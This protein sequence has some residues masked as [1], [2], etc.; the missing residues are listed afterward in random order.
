MCVPS[1]GEG[2]V[3]GSGK[4]PGTGSRACTRASFVLLLKCM[5]QNFLPRRVAGGG[6]T[7]GQG[8]ARIAVHRPS[9]ACLIAACSHWGRCSCLSPSRT[10]QWACIVLWH[11]FLE[12]G[13]KPHHPPPPS[14]WKKGNS[15]GKSVGKTLSGH[16][17]YKKVWVPDPPLPLI[18]PCPPPA[19]SSLLKHSSPPAPHSSLLI[20]PQGPELPSMGS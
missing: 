17:W 9:M 2:L 12:K 19:S 5:H 11:G 20:H 18:H 14:S 4:P 3:A 10:R 13:D 1:P 7:S 8:S 15:L 16:L 6:R